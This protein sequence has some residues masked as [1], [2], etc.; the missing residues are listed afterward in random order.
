MQKKTNCHDCKQ[1]IYF[2]FKK[3]I[4]NLILFIL[5]TSCF[6]ND[7]KVIVDFNGPSPAPSEISFHE[8]EAIHIGIASIISPKE[9]FD[10][11]NDLLSYISQK[12]GMPV[13]YIQKESYQEINDLLSQNIVDFAFIGTGA[14]VKRKKRRYHAFW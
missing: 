6:S 14:Y 13:H 3:Y 4:I 11:Y 2:M 8:D 12:I 7:K 1:L 5:L 9:S 10:Y